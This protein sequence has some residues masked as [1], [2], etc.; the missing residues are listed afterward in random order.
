MDIRLAD[1]G[2]RGRDKEEKPVSDAPTTESLCLDVP[3]S[4]R[5]TAS[6]LLVRRLVCTLNDD[7]SRN[8][9]LASKFLSLISAV[10]AT[11]KDPFAVW[12]RSWTSPWLDLSFL[13]HRPCPNVHSFH[14]HCGS[15]ATIGID[16]GL[17]LT[18][19]L[20]LPAT[21]RRLLHRCITVTTSLDL[22][23]TIC[24]S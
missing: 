8:A 10:S 3:M 20:D 17:F 23:R 2:L 16:H 19:W 6:S 18:T 4:L 9:T 15:L 5:C 24:F 14:G 12:S 21:L 11:S 7:A 22:D 13:A 1:Q